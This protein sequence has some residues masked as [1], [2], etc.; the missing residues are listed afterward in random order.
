MRIL[1]ISAAFAALLGGTIAAQADGM[2]GQASYKDAVAVTPF[3]WTG[4]YFGG[5]VGFGAGTTENNSDGSLL[6]RDQEVFSLPL[7]NEDSD[8]NGAVYGLHVG[9]NIQRGHLVYGLE[10]TLSG[11]DLDSSRSCGLLSV[12]KCESELDYYGT[13]V[14]RLGYAVDKTLF[15]VTGGLAYGEVSN[16]LSLEA[17]GFKLPLVKDEETAV[18]WTAGIGIEHAMTDRFIVRIEYAHIDLGDDSASKTFDFG[19]LGLKVDNKT[20][21][22]F[23]TIRIGASYKLGHRHEALEPLK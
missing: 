22:E 1:T 21:L 8:L 10:A 18:G 19:P 14:G 15:Y 4:L 23:D 12:F 7:V 20:D 2:Y 16:N 6:I 5:S 9:Y 3:S 17:L 11:A 13:V